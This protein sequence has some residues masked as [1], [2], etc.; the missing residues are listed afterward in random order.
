MLVSRGNKKLG[1]DTLIFNMTS[2]TDCPSKAL[3]LCKI[4]NICYAM[5]AERLYPHSLP[6]RRRQAEYWANSTAD[7]I[8]KDFQEE[9]NRKTQ[10]P[11]KYIRVSEAGDF[12]SQEDVD[13]LFKVVEL[14]ANT[15]VKVYVYTAR[16]DLDFSKA[17]Q[18]LTIQGSGFMVHNSF[19]ATRKEDV[20]PTDIVCPGDCKICNMCKEH[21]NLDIK[22]I[23]H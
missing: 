4:C 2:A 10:V 7:K 9:I 15:G 17:P 3:G 12:R 6:Y 18:S 1:K 5:K 21:N 20:K 16:K 23:N 19:T 14:L 11:I 8:A 13:K 22:V